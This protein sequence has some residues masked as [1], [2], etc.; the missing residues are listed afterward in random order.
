VENLCDRN[1]SRARSSR[2]SGDNRLDWL[3]NAHDSATGAVGSRAKHHQ[4]WIRV[5]Q[6]EARREALDLSDYRLLFQSVSGYNSCN[7]G[8]TVS[9]P[10]LRCNQMSE[11]AID[12]VVTE[13]NGF[14]QRLAMLK[15]EYARANRAMAD[16]MAQLGE[17]LTR[18]VRDLRDQVTNAPQNLLGLESRF[19]SGDIPEQEYKS[20]REEYRNQLQTNLRSIDEIRSLLMVM[21]QLEMR[22]G[23][24]SGTGQGSMSPRP[25]PTD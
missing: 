6:L 25:S 24:A 21:S 5:E 14:R 8:C 2:D 11:V 17:N 20:T 22:P 1:S 10:T 18:R 19:M 12:K 7:C 13:I 9:Q 23:T 3:D 4:H 16:K 15:E